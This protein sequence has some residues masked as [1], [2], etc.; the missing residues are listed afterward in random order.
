MAVIVGMS[1]R[2]VLWICPLSLPT[3]PP[4]ELPADVEFIECRDAGDVLS[5]LE[6]GEDASFDVVVV[7][8]SPMESNGY[9][10]VDAVTPIADRCSVP[11]RYLVAVV[12]R[13]LNVDYPDASLAFAAE[14]HGLWRQGRPRLLIEEAVLYRLE[15]VVGA[16]TEEQKKRA[17]SM[18][19]EASVGVSHAGPPAKDQISRQHRRWATIAETAVLL[20]QSGALAAEARIPPR[21]QVFVQAMCAR[22]GEG[23][24]PRLSSSQRELLHALSA[25]RM[26]VR[27]LAKTLFIGEKEVRKKQAEIASR[28]SPYA[29]EDPVG[30]GEFCDRLV[31]RYSPWL[32]SHAQRSSRP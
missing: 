8:T 20:T 15:R 7:D 6:R 32:H 17:A 11:P 19:G 25:K 14:I 10:P 29:D 30:P 9:D 3:I 21:I 18:G 23:T 5:L 27:E 16:V 28:L 2:R 31:D 13:G 1:M 4:A 22:R 24:G 26:S 12:M